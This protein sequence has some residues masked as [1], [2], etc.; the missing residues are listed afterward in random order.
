[1]TDLRDDG[2]GAGVDALDGDERE[3]VHGG[4]DHRE[5]E[6]LGRVL[7]QP[8][9]LAHAR[10][11]ARVRAR[12]AGVVVVEWCG[13]VVKWCGVVGVLGWE[14]RGARMGGAL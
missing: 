1:M 3:H 8:K 14:L 4:V 5:E 2:E 12:I 6:H 9:H 10:A 7:N 13:V 11:C